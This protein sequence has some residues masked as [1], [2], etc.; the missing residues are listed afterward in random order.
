MWLWE[1]VAVKKF[2]TLSPEVSFQLFQTIFF[3]LTGVGKTSLG[4]SL[5]RGL[6]A[7]LLS[8]KKERDDTS[9]TERTRGVAVRPI[10]LPG[11]FPGFPNAEFSLWDY[12][13][14]EEVGSLIV[15]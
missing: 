15:Q 12:A 10:E 11:F 4:N 13:G 8:E 5:E 3:V 7:S 14:Q 2:T 6:I 9:V 1:Y